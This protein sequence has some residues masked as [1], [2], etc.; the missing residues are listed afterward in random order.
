MQRGL[1]IQAH[2]VA[3]GYFLLFNEQWG[4]Y[5]VPSR[6]YM[7]FPVSFTSFCCKMTSID[8]YFS[9]KN[10]NEDE[11]ISGIKLDKTGVYY[12]SIGK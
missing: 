1:A 10:I 4:Y 7:A 5:D 3:T 6:T 8:F 11:S 9:T 12:V 2:V